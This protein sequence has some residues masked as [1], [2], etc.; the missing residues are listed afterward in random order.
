MVAWFPM[1]V[2]AGAVAAVNTLVSHSG[3]SAAAAAAL[4]HQSGNPPAI[5]PP[6]PSTP[7]LSGNAVGA[8]AEEFGHAASALLPRAAPWPA[9]GRHASS[10]TLAGC[11]A[12]AGRHASS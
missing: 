4:V 10:C 1:D 12:M 3:P 6:P 2:E 7:M 8:A 5:A 9:V 11:R